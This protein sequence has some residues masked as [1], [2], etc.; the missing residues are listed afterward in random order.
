MQQK[1]ETELMDHIQKL[2]DQIKVEEL[3]SQKIKDFIA[4]KRKTIEDNADEREGLREQK[5]KDLGIA[6]EEIQN[7]Q[8]EASNEIA[9]MQKLMTQQNEERKQN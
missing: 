3:C 4:K 6:K 9:N 1:K 8:E 2:K 7:K 5:L